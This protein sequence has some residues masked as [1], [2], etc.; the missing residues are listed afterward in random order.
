M[1]IIR[2]I[3]LYMQILYDMFIMHLCKQSGRLEDV[4]DTA[5]CTK[6]KERQSLFS[7]L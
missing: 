6:T 2:K 7:G 5:T 4:L 1:F 3:L